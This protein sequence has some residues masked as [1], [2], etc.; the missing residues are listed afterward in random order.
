ML[1]ALWFARAPVPGPGPLAWT[2]RLAL[3]HAVLLAPSLGALPVRWSLFA[4]AM[5][6]PFLALA[7]WGHPAAAI[8]DALL[9]LVSAVACGAAGAHLRARAY[10]PSIVALLALPYGLGYLCEEFGRPGLASTFRRLSPWTLHPGAAV[11]LLWIWPLG[12]L[13]RRRR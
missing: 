4:G 3:L 10:L 6:L 2:T 8:R 7:S 9:L 12:A 11:F 13:A 5:A 1:C